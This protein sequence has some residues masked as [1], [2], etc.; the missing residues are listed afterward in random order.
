[1]THRHA[2]RILSLA[3]AL[4][5]APRALHATPISGEA[6]RLF[7]TPGAPAEHAPSTEHRTF[8]E[9]AASADPFA[10]LAAYD[11]LADSKGTALSLDPNPRLTDDAA[12]DVRLLEPEGPRGPGLL[13]VFALT[14]CGAL[15]LAAFRTE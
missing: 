7:D 4:A 14:G 10:P 2:I 8:S 6:P 5:A 15:G 9:Q 11:S 13:W 1:M 12:L 3:L